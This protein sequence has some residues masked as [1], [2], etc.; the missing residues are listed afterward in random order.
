MLLPS[1]CTSDC[2]S[3]HARSDGSTRTCTPACS[4]SSLR[5]RV[6]PAVYVRGSRTDPDRTSYQVSASPAGTSLTTG[7]DA[8][9]LP[10]LTGVRTLSTSV[11]VHPWFRS[12]LRQV[13]CTTVRTHPFSDL[14]CGVGECATRHAAIVADRS[15]HARADA[16]DAERTS[17]LSTAHWSS[18]QRIASANFIIDRSVRGY[19]IP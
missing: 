8:T 13:R 1:A 17:A 15:A 11:R 14:A 7:P 16:G 6:S 10:T 18:R 5:A 9:A 12:L 2:R 4:T 3:S 19:C